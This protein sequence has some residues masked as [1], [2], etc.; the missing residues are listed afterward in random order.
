M[1]FGFAVKHYGFFVMLYGSQV[2]TPLLATFL[3]IFLNVVIAFST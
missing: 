1:P 2:Q 3:F